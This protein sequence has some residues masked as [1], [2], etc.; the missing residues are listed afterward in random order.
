M[1]PQTVTITLPTPIYR[2]VKQQSQLTHRSIAEELV[3]VVT[4][5]SLQYALSNDIEQELTQ[6][7]LFTERE[8]WQAAQ[9]KVSSE[10]TDAMQVLVEK[11]QREGLTDQERQQTQVLSHFFN[12]VMLIR[13]KAAA[14]LK[15]RGHDVSTLVSD[16]E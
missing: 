16:H 12:R 4:D 15:Q 13:A 10:A 9:T 3:A 1:N 6:L 2:Y 11:Q 8:L 7:D 5:Y 14:I